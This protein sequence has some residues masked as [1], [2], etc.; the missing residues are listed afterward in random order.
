MAMEIVSF[1]RKHWFLLGLVG[2][3]LLANLAPSIGK[4]GGENGIML[5]VWRIPSLGSHCVLKAVEKAHGCV[6]RHTQTRM[7]C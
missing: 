7:D 3:I 1:I 2:V 5:S 6:L 4:K